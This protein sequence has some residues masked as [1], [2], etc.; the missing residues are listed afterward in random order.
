MWARCVN[1][2]LAWNTQ[3]NKITDV[4]GK[5][6]EQERKGRIKN[7]DI[8]LSRTKYNYDL[9]PSDLNLYQRVKERVEYAKKTGSRVQKNS[10]VMYSNILTVPREQA[11]LWGEEKTHA[12]FKACYDFFSQEFGKENVVSAKV[13]LDESAPHMHLHFVPFNKETGKLQARVVMDRKKINQIHNDLPK[14]LRERGFDVVRGSGKTS[15]RNIK[16]IHEYKAVQ[17]KISEKQK[18]LEQMSN[19]IPKVKKP[20]PFVKKEKLT[21]VVK[22]GIFLKE[23]QEKE[24][25]N[26]I[27][28]AKQY[29]QM[30]EMMNAAIALKKYYE[31]MRNTDLAIEN[32][33]LRENLAKEKVKRKNIEKENRELKTENLTLKKETTFLKRHIS[34]LRAEID[35]TYKTIKNFIKEHTRDASTFKS[36]LN[37]VVHRIKEGY[38]LL[39]QK[40]GKNLGKS[41]FEQL[42][43]RVSSRQFKRN[44]DMQR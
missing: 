41:E 43:E 29:E 8:D 33:Q 20:V 40:N 17:Q 19:V 11:D 36:T 4:K 44:H 3:K 22:K 24:T 31:T 42:H 9:V 39:H 13:H 7:A 14:F 35:L 28:S 10:V 37:H 2:E 5:E 21:E 32:K 25:G 12:Y 16:D 34:D 30:T 6:R 38:F 26:Y 15:E 27:L 23:E 1:L 18:E